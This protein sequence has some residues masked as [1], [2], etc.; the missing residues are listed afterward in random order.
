MSALTERER[1]T[2][3]LSGG[4]WSCCSEPLIGPAEIVERVGSNRAA[5]NVHLSDRGRKGVILGR[6]YIPGTRPPDSEHA[7]AGFR[8]RGR[9][10]PSTRTRW[11]W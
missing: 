6:G 11:S 7:A 2:V 3:E 9:R 5:V 1:G 4:S 8:A 10:I